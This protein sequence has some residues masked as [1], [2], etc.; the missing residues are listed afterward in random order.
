M[1]KLLGIMCILGGCIGWGYGRAREEK[2]RVCHLRE[3]IRIIRRIQSEMEYGKRTLPEICV[4]LA[5]C[6]S[7]RYRFCFENIYEHMARRDGTGIEQ[8]WKEQTEECLKG[9]P[10]LS[11]EKD[12]L[13]MLP[14]NLGMPEETLQAVNIGQSLDMMERRLKQ[15]EESYSGKVR[16]ILSVSALAGI[17]IVILIL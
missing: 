9:I 2:S 10:L 15:A 7:G 1:L 3:I 5:A 8:V 12:V 16:M 14:Q 6:S 13:R 11:E 17:F 4:V